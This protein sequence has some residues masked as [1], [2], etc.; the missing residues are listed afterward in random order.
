[1]SEGDD[2]NRLDKWLAALEGDIE[3]ADAEAG[4]EA[5]D[6]EGVK[7]AR[8]KQGP[9]PVPSGPAESARLLAAMKE[10]DGRRGPAA[11]SLAKADRA[12]RRA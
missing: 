10:I 4:T 9:D 12:A 5:E 3:V 11:P 1:M 2:P 8:N 7:M 6:D